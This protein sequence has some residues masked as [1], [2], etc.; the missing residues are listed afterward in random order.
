M[1]LGDLLDQGANG[2]S[3]LKR[4][5]YDLL[6]IDPVA[7]SL[8]ELMTVQFDLVHIEQQRGHRTIQ[9]PGDCDTGL[10]RRP[11]PC[12]GQID[13]CEIAFE[14]GDVFH[15]LWELRIIGSMVCLRHL[16]NLSV[17]FSFMVNFPIRTN[18]GM[19]LAQPLH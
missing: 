10:F 5:F 18:T 16:T 8:R 9:L 12:G 6:Q 2:F 1:T 14:R 15:P 7:G 11:D 4:V 3:L 19:R 13:K 17:P